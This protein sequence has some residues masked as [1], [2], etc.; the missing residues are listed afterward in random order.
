MTVQ[1][2]KCCGV[3]AVSR[4]TPTGLNPQPV[5]MSSTL[6]RSFLCL[7]TKERTKG[8]IKAGEKMADNFF[9]KLKRMKYASFLADTRDQYSF[10]TLRSEIVSTPFFLRPFYQLLWICS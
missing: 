5:A 1:L 7:D 10:S 9:A 4:S 6:I 3:A 8:K 2:K